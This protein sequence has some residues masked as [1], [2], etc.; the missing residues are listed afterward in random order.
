MRK[1][2]EEG[3]SLFYN[4]NYS[5]LFSIFRLSPFQRWLSESKTCLA[6]LHIYKWLTW[7][8]IPKKLDSISLDNLYLWN[9]IAISMHCNV[10]ISS[11]AALIT[12]HSRCRLQNLPNLVHNLIKHQNNQTVFYNLLST[13]DW[14]FSCEVLVY[15]S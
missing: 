15:S 9:Y 5:V 8:F 2:Q 7:Y 1:K 14:N 12:F 4:L 11:M 3:I 6:L 13:A 10:M